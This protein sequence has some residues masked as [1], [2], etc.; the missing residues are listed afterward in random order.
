MKTNRQCAE[1]GALLPAES[2]QGLCPRCLLKRGL[3]NPTG[4]TAESLAETMVE[5]GSAKPASTTPPREGQRFGDYQLVRLLGQ[6]GMGAV[7][8]AEHLPSERRVALKVLTHRLEAP[9]ARQRFLREGRLAAS[10]NHPNCV[11]V[12]GTEEID[13][14]PV[15]AMELAPGG[16]L[17]ERVREKGPRP[18]PEAVDTILQVMEGL[19]AAHDKE[20][21]HRDVKP[22]NCFIDKDGTVKVGDFGLSISRLA[23]GETNLTISGTFLGTPAFSSP[24]Q[25]RGDELD[26]RSDIYSVGVTLYF[27]L[28][29]RTPF[30]GDNVVRLLATVLERAPESPAKLRPEI[31]DGLAE[32]VLRCLEKQPGKRYKD[33]DGIR[34]ALFP[35]SSTAPKPAP[36]F[37]RFRACVVDTL[38]CQ[39]VL[40]GLVSLLARHAPAPSRSLQIALNLTT[41]VLIPV[42]YLAVQE[43]LWGRTLGKLLFRVRVVS[44]NRDQPRL[45]RAFLRAALFLAAPYALAVA[46]VVSVGFDDT[47]LPLV[48]VLTWVLWLAFQM[49]LFS[50]ARLNNGYAGIHDLLSRTRVI[51]EPEQS[52]R[53]IFRIAD[54]PV[55][56]LEAAGKI[57]P[58]HILATLRK[59]ATEELL[60]GYDSRLLRKV[61]IHKR[62]ASEPSVRPE[63]RNLSRPGR[64]RWL[65]GRRSAN[66]CWDAY[67][68]VAGKPLLGLL[69]EP[70]PWDR[71]RYWLL[72]LAEEFEA[73]T[74]DH[75]APKKIGLESVW[76]SKEG[77]A[78]LLDFP[79]PG[80]EIGFAGGESIVPGSNETTTRDHDPAPVKDA[81]A[82]QFLKQVAITALQGRAV[83][84]PDVP[85]CLPEV[86]MALYAR[87]FLERMPSFSDMASVIAEVRP[88]LSKPSLASRSQRAALGAGSWGLPLT[89]AAVSVF[90]LGETSDSIESRIQAV[91]MG[92][93]VFALVFFVLPNF[94]CAS[95]FWEAPL[96]QD[97]GLAYV[98]AKGSKASGGELAVK[99]VLVWSPGLFYWVLSPTVGALWA[100]IFVLAFLAVVFVQAV[101]TPQR[102][103]A[104][105]LAGIWLVPR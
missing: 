12:F 34:Q 97:A 80:H 78:L 48:E 63:L 35:F 66:E 7:Y 103:L 37:V 29:G 64:L 69:H 102:S 98:T 13:G 89:I 6:G 4:A 104:D 8:E 56:S 95:L 52:K 44:L 61:W 25:L 43:G 21:L 42:I 15:I 71:V 36:L 101:L 16:T 81:E 39:L 38:V 20:V 40:T 19:Q 53:P 47:A 54:E 14:I 65:N 1:C 76:I 62:P 96:A 67:E 72:D 74:K 27:L 50:T 49:L 57:G 82:R 58:Y 31:P 92:N 93:F 83:K 24:E 75:T 84:C 33:Y 59:T 41:S 10:V 73:G 26:V 87:S 46:S 88:L 94:I 105:R 100:T 17:K 5:T 99:T 23:R 2:P 60:L 28:T 91:A 70:Q 18:I 9:E 3:D 79:A 22:S 68:A 77:R 55:P 86:P 51:W 32:I 11:Y 90:T 30:A 45:P 85:D